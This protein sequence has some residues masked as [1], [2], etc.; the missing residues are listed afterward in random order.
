M[1]D[2]ELYATQDQ[3]MQHVNTKSK[4]TPTMPIP[5]NW[6]QSPFTD[7]QPMDWRAWTP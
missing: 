6:I 4:A 2:S 7:E 5:I 3:G 1:L